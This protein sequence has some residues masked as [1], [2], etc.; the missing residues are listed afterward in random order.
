MSS[1]GVSLLVRSIVRDQ[2]QRL[3]R[4]RVKEGAVLLTSVFSSPRTTLPLLAATTR[5]RVGSTEAFTAAA[6]GIRGNTGAI[7][8][9]TVADGV[10]SVLAVAGD[11]PTPGTTITGGRAALA[12]RAT[13][14]EDMVTA[15]VEEPSGRQLVF[16]RTA[17]NG[18]V[19][20]QDYPL[21]GP[22]A[23]YR[24]RPDDPFS[25]LDGVVYAG[26]REDPSKV[27][28]TT[29]ANLPLSGRIERQDLQVGADTWLLVARSNQPLVGS[30]AANAPWGVLASG[31]LAALLATV[32]VETLSRRRAYALALVEERTVALR[33]A[34][35][36]A[37]AASRSKSEFLSRMSHE[38]RTP[39]NAVLGFGQ[40][41]EL[42]DLT[43]PQREAVEQIV[44]GGRHLLDLINEVLDISRIE[45][46]N[47]S[48]SPEP[49]L[50]GEVVTDTLTL[51]RPLADDGSVEIV[52]QSGALE[53]AHVLADRQRLKQILLN[54]VANA[55][56]YNRTGGRVT[57]STEALDDGRVRITVADTGV[58]IRAEDFDRLFVPFERLG[59]GTAEVEGTGVGLALS[60]R[61]AEAMGGTIEVEST[62]GDGSR[63]SVLLPR[64]EG[65]LERF[66]RTN[67]SE[68]ADEAEGPTPRHRI[69]YVEDNVSNVRLVE[70][71][72]EGR[73][74][75]EVIPAMQGRLAVDLAHE[76]RP[77]LI[78]LDLHLPDIGGAEVLRHLR[79]DPVT[80]ETPVVVVSADATAGQVER[81]LAAGA[82]G[83]LTK[84]LDVQEL[85][86][87][88]ARTIDP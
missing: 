40:L 80:A 38:L 58:G 71:V 87:V 51:M 85:R 9:L 53:G 75:V 31:L 21:L 79:E 32:L 27:V 26:R 34:R 88:V 33:E 36:L 46:G 13:G 77:A 55:V 74:D 61:L 37:E 17:G 12:M 45:A 69:L 65:P 3:L 78:L 42:D 44:K 60:H 39:L 41:L 52:H 70:R 84:P 25:E 28:L 19:L 20:Y 2:E 11:G 76:H 24:P 23:T 73:G 7:G 29:G 62:Y 81:L 67:G 54:L 56:K 16:A 49:V 50:V 63:F 30:F 66:E 10:V 6:M 47:L 22:S 1:L 43:G 83:Y 68:P 59:A 4:E 72:L 35:E 82:S 15:V 64:A 5:P 86:A 48:L 18:L 8:A 14:V 57:V